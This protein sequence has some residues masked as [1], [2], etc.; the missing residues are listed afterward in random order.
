MLA[1]LNQTQVALRQRQAGRARQ[2]AE[3]RDLRHAH[4]AGLCD[5]RGVAVA[6]D[7]PIVDAALARA[8]ASGDAA[9][10][11]SLRELIKKCLARSTAE[12]EAEVGFDALDTGIRVIHPISG[13]EVR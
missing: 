12:A 13:E 7:H 11:G 5:D 10:S 8:D 1:G 6:A 9:L 4:G 3:D 2:E